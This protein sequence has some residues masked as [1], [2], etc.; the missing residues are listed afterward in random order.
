MLHPIFAGRYPLQKFVIFRE[1]FRINY[2][3]S[4]FNAT[5]QHVVRAP[6][7]HVPK[8]R[9]GDVVSAKRNVVSPQGNRVSAKGN[10]VS[11]EGNVV[12]RKGN[13]VPAKGN[14]V[15]AEGNVVS[16][17]G[18][19]QVAVACSISGINVIVPVLLCEPFHNH[20]S[21]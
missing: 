21:H 6:S 7:K 17:K 9:C 4:K 3:K 11:A 20:E 8:R 15:S 1:K 5:R 19:E 13:R 2:F 16:R 14:V 18:S 10:V 12:S